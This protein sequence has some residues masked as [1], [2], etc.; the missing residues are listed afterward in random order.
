MTCTLP[1]L[2][3]SHVM[4]PAQNCLRICKALLALHFS[5]TAGAASDPDVLLPAF[6]HDPLLTCKLLFLT[7]MM[8]ATCKPA[9]DCIAALV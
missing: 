7:I 4:L 1:L 8:L 2:I 5:G 9:A 6:L 3:D